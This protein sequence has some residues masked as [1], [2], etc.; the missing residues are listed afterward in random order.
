M[1]SFN[2]QQRDPK[3]EKLDRL[4]QVFYHM[5]INMELLEACHLIS[6]ILVD[7]AS[8]VNRRLSYHKPPASKAF[9]KLFVLHERPAFQGPPEKP[10]DTCVWDLFRGASVSV[11]AREKVLQR[12]Q[13]ESPRS[14]L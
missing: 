10:Q 2:Y 5:H 6:A 8:M 12:T 4:R 9:R 14:Y 3:Q 7:V 11:K 13:S 1:Q